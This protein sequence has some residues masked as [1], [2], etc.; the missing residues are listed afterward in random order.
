MEAIFM[1]YS[2]SERL[3]Y[4]R[5][6]LSFSEVI[7]YLAV[8]REMFRLGVAAHELLYFHLLFFIPKELASHTYLARACSMRAMSKHVYTRAL[9]GAIAGLV[10]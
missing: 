9:S 3:L 8:T 10:P 5:F 2:I 6:S 4:V 1:I 7:S